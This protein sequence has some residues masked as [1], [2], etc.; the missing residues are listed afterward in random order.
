VYGIRRAGKRVVY[1]GLTEGDV[2]AARDCW[3]NDAVWHVPGRSDFAGDCGPDAYL[4]MLGEW[5]ARYPN[6]AFASREVGQFDHAAVFFIE[7]T[8]GMAPERASWLLVYRVTAGMLAEGWAVPALGD[9]YL[10][11]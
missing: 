9:G 1:A 5:V 4:V 3:A 11:F 7:S 6:Y 8:G 10:L 2:A